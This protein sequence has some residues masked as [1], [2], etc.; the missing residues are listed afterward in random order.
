M[1]SVCLMTMGGTI[2]PKYNYRC[3]SCDKEWV[4]WSSMNNTDIECPY[5]FKGDVKKVP[6]GS[7][8]IV[9]NSSADEQK[10]AKENVIEHIEENRDILKQMRGDAKKEMGVEDV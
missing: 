4:Q 1:S 6:P 5:C 7:F 2:V 10:S 9:N 8:Y 3:D